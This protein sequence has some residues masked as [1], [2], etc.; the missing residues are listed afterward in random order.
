MD[1]DIYDYCCCNRTRRIQTSIDG[2][3]LRCGKCLICGLSG[4]YRQMPGAP[5]AFKAGWCEFHY[6][7]IAETSTKQMQNV[8]ATA[9]HD[10]AHA[11]HMICGR[12]M[13]TSFHRD[14]ANSFF[15]MH[16]SLAF[17]RDLWDYCYNDTESL[18]NFMR[19]FPET[20]P[21]ESIASLCTRF[22]K[23]MKCRS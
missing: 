7:K 13:G 2:Y 17:N 9:K 18:A 23:Q 21:Y 10:P 14:Q 6:G 4:H 5:K 8:F 12:D 3:N 22:V 20:M 16:K 1:D 15:T 19:H 11:A